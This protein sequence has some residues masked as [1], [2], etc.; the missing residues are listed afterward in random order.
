MSEGHAGAAHFG[1][2]GIPI[3]GG[4]HD[5]PGAVETPVTESSAVCGPF[6][7]CGKG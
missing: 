1:D 2:V 3:G 7:E 4:S 6:Q 5:Q